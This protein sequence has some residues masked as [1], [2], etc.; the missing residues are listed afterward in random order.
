MSEIDEKLRK[1]FNEL[2]PEKQDEFING[3]AKHFFGEQKPEIKKAEYI[4]KDKVLAFLDGCIEEE[5]GKFY[6]QVVVKAIRKTIERMPTIEVEDGE[7]S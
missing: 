1:R 2:P 7:K 4:R 6:P 5:E 3:F